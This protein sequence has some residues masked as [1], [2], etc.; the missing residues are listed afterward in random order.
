[1]I[2]DLPYAEHQFPLCGACGG[3]TWHDGDVLRCD[4][5]GLDYGDGNRAALYLDDAAE[6]C[7]TAY[8]FGHGRVRL[9]VGDP[10]QYTD[11]PLPRGHVS[12]HYHPIQWVH[13]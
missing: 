3:E 1:M 10:Y 8:V 12:E 5:C 4:D 11:C 9:P 13:P 6:P 2:G 7:G